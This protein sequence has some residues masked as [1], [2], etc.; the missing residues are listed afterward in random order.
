MTSATKSWL[1]KTL[2]AAVLAAV[3]YFA[4][5]AALIHWRLDRLIFS[6]QSHD[7]THESQRY[8]IAVGNDANI[9][10]RRYNGS[11]SACIFFF[12]GQHGGI[13]RCE[14]TLFP[15]LRTSGAM[16][17]AVSYPGQDG[18]GGQARLAL[19]FD[20]V[21]SAVR[22]VAHTAN[23]D[24]SQSVFIGRSLGATV[25]LLEAERIRPAG[26]VVDGLG[27]N[28][29]VVIRAWIARHPLAGGWQWLPIQRLLGGHFYP[30]SPVLAHLTDIPIA[31]FQGTADDVTPFSEAQAVVQGHASVTFQ[32]VQGGRHDNSY[33]LA[34]PQYLQVLHAMTRTQR[35]GV[36]R[37]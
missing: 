19:L 32:P 24:L 37:R 31:V 16:V 35:E 14:R 34:R 25:A 11:G 27:A 8:R 1:L 5:P 4:L 29:A 15:Y 33:L 26:V 7:T 28:L 23:C 20:Q 2:G 22:A 12:P 9:I 17:F 30:V 3:F 36:V 21:E 18:S 6:S 10:V 13:G